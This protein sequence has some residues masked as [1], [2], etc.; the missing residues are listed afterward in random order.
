[1]E[2]HDVGIV[3]QSVRP[4]QY[5]QH[6]QFSA[7]QMTVGLGIVLLGNDMQTITDPS[8]SHKPSLAYFSSL[9]TGLLI[10]VTVFLT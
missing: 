3:T 8:S 9:A 5:H 2:V 6:W 4:V 7:E 10:M 1:V